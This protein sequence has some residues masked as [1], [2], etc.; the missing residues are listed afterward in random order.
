[1]TRAGL[2]L[3]LLAAGLLILLM[4]APDSR[5]MGLS[6]Q[7]LGQLVYLLPILT[8]LAAGILASRRNWGQSARH[9]SIW[10]AIILVLAGASLFR[11]DMKRAGARMLAGLL[12]GRA[13]TVTGEDGSREVILSRGLSGHFTAV[14]TVNAQDIPM[15]VDTGASTVT[16]TYED[17]VAVGIIPENLVYSTRVLT[18]NGE[19]TAAPIDLS[20]VDLGPIRRQNIPALVTRRGAMDQSLLGMSFLSTLS[21][22]HMQ[23]DE[24]RLKD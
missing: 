11:E 7:Q 22:F 6:E 9:L 8:M 15:L 1:M 16:L 12:P 10:L 13:I 14:V 17:A 18:A 21:S 4:K 23:T 24:L 2:A 3:A 20:M 5:L 19:A